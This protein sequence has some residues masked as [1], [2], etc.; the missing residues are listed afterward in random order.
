MEIGWQANDFGL[1]IDEFFLSQRPLRPL[2]KGH[3]FGK[4]FERRFQ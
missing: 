3:P 1:T 4:Y 2:R